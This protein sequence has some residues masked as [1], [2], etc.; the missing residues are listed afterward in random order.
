[1]EFASELDSFLAAA[2][3]KRKQTLVRRMEA[4]HQEPCKYS[5]VSNMHDGKEDSNVVHDMIQQLKK[6]A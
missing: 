1:M 4:D 3:Q 6:N 5:F 2:H